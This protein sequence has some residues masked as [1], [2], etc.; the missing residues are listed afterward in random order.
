MLETAYTAGTGLY[1]WCG[2]FH[3]PQTK[4]TATWT[5]GG[6]ADSF[7]RHAGQDQNLCCRPI[8]T[9]CSLSS[10]P[11]VYWSLPYFV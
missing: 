7:I 5:G 8:A 2:I 4:K 3:T 9:V 6:K 11:L 1:S 10:L